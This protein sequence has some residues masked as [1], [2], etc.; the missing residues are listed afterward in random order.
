MASELSLWLGLLIARQLVLKG[1]IPR[2]SFWRVNIP[3][4]PR[5]S[6]MTVYEPASEVIKH[7]YCYSLLV[8]VIIRL[9]RFKKKAHRSLPLK[10]GMSNN[11]GSF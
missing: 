11:L 1:S 6:C 5:G 7:H 2:E 10:G 3:R 9:L 4:E 8:E